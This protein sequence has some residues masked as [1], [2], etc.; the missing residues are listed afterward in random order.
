MTEAATETA[1]KTP[2]AKKNAPLQGVGCLIYDPRSIFE[3]PNARY[4]ICFSYKGPHTGASDSQYLIGA[5]EPME[6]LTI[7]P[8]AANMIPREVWAKVREHGQ[9]SEMIQGYMDRG[10]LTWIEPEKI[11]GQGSIVDFSSNDAMRI[12]PMVNDLQILKTWQRWQSSNPGDPI[13]S[14]IESRIKILEERN[15]RLKYTSAE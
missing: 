4:P 11:P 12:I 2:A 6:R 9:N 10:V 5:V 15:S 1:P 13:W 3:V 8:G 7:A 14:A